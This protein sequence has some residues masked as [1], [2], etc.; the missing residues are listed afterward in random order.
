MTLWCRKPGHGKWKLAGFSGTPQECTDE[1]VR[2]A[3]GQN[4]D[5]LAMLADIDPNKMTL[6]EPIKD[7]EL[8]F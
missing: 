3:H 5:W 7:S 1:I 6:S 4:M 8:P 2:R